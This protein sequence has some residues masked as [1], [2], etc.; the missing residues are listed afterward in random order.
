MKNFDKNY[1][2]NIDLTDEEYEIIRNN[3]LNN[4]KTRRFKMKYAYILILIVFVS[5]VGAVSASK[6]INQMKINI[7][8]E[9]HI[10]EIT[11]SVTIDE[12]YDS[13]LFEN[14]NY[15]TYDEIEEKL[16]FK[17]LKSSHYDSDLFIASPEAVDGKLSSVDFIMVNSDKSWMYPWSS[18]RVYVATKYSD[19]GFHFKVVGPTYLE[20][21]YIKSLGVEANILY[22]ASPCIDAVSHFVYNGVLYQLQLEIGNKY[23]FATYE[24]FVAT[25]REKMRNDIIEIL[26]SFTLE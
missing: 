8:E 16:G 9:K 24:E 19:S 18:F 2:K 26:E 17:L 21:Y 6:I 11:S 22:F 1:F 7:N 4:K 12:D 3:I 10:K 20:T 15:Y 13:A 23:S 5:F 25:S 14:G